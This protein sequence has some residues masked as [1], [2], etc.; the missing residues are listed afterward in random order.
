MVD[1]GAYCIDADELGTGSWFVAAAACRDRFSAVDTTGA[2]GARLCS[3]AEWYAACEDQNDGTAIGMNNSTNNFEWVD[4]WFDDMTAMV[5]GQF[6][7]LS[8]A[9]STP[10]TTRAYRCC[11]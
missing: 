5:M 9:G 6:S 11:Q 3:A 2:C 10:G 1:V 4:D 7:C 8:V